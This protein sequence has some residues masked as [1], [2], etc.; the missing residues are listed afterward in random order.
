MSPIYRL[1]LKLF[2]S[3][4]EIVSSVKSA[5]EMNKAQVSDTNMSS[6]LIRIIFLFVIDWTYDK[7]SGSSW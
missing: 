5:S 6:L 7:M 2:C 1:A 4:K 3:L